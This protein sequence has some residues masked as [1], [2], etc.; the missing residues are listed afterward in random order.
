MP[1]YIHEL[2]DWP[3][4]HWD[5]GRLAAQLAS[6][7]HLQGR[8]VGQMETKS[9]ARSST[10]ARSAPQSLAGSESI[11]AGCSLQTVTSKASS[12]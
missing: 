2:P 9:K 3:R 1:T 8:L 12:R 5:A 10:P 6:A 7:R 4:F 11:S